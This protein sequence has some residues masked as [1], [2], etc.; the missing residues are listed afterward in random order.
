MIYFSETRWY[1]I[2]A[3]VFSSDGPRRSYLK[4]KLWIDRLAG[5]VIG[6][7]RFKLVSE[8]R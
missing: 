1:A 6:L 4:S 3:V 7:L 8:A 2:V 5:G